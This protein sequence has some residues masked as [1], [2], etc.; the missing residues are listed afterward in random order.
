M[1]GQSALLVHWNL[2]RSDESV[3]IIVVTTP[4]ITPP[5]V[6]R[7]ILCP[8]WGSVSMLVLFMSAVDLYIERER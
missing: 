1:E 7:I 3:S 6:H 2:S 8:G 5:L 4:L